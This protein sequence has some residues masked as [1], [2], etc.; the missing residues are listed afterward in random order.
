MSSGMGG[1][2]GWD[3]WNGNKDGDVFVFDTST[4]AGNAISALS[5]AQCIVVYM[6]GGASYY[7][8]SRV[9]EIGGTTITAGSEATL[10]ATA[11]HGLSVGALTATKAIA[12]YCDVYSDYAGKGKV[13]TITT[14]TKAISFGTE[15]EFD[16]SAVGSSIVT[17]RISD[18][19][20]LVVYRTWTPGTSNSGGSACLVTLDGTNGVPETPVVFETGN[21]SAVDVCMLS[22]TAFIVAYISNGYGRVIYGAISGTTV[23]FPVSNMYL[24]SDSISMGGISIAGLS[25]TKA[26][27]CFS[28]DYAKARVFTVSGTTITPGGTVVLAP[29]KGL[30]TDAVKI[31]ETQAMCL[32]K[33]YSSPYYGTGC[34]V[35][36]EAATPTKRPIAVFNSAVTNYI[37]ATQI[38][39]DKIVVAYSD[40]A[41]SPYEGTAKVLYGG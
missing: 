5:D 37:A 21:V 35:T 32:Y 1:L 30:Y 17:A 24:E 41:G 28:T 7:G 19:A 26:M 9:L 23:S 36:S 3:S 10:K 33:N 29:T 16:S 39:S 14:A 25:S 6:D 40:Y 22:D 13:A 20:A 2:S 11:M 8:K 18:T 12:S 4:V 34:V 15:Y 31:S 27:A 38:A